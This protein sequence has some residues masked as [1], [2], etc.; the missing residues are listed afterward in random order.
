MEAG[1]QILCFG[2][3]RPWAPLLDHHVP[4][5]HVLG[6]VLGVVLGVLRDGGQKGGLVA[7]MGGSEVDGWEW[8]GRWMRVCVVAVVVWCLLWTF[9][10]LWWRCDTRW[11]RGE[12][13]LPF[14]HMGC[15]LLYHLFAF[16]GFFTSKLISSLLSSSNV[17]ELLLNSSWDLVLPHMSIA[18]ICF[19]GFELTDKKCS[20]SVT[21]HPPAQRCSSA[22]GLISSCWA[23]P[24]SLLHWGSMCTSS[25]FTSTLDLQK[26]MC[27]C[28]L[29]YNLDEKHCKMHI[30]AVLDTDAVRFIGF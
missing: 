4:L 14:L 19:G 29:N 7:A 6:P 20:L 24:S 25:C 5:V 2:L 13:S 16:W 26:I 3:P 11:R 21:I 23:C 1:L 17:F 10:Q 8:N 9:F 30:N 28:A 27:L 12:A 18:S 22:F 15:S